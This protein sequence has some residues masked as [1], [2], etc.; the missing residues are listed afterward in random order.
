MAG[1]TFPAAS[2]GILFTNFSRFHKTTSL[3]EKQ[4][5]RKRKELLKKMA[6]GQEIQKK[7]RN[8]ETV[9]AF[10]IGTYNPATKGKGRL[11]ATIFKS[12]DSSHLVA[13]PKWH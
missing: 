3:L 5:K 10:L 12:T 8:L 1:I 9:N 7:E 4:K 11:Q 2:A 6:T 13:S